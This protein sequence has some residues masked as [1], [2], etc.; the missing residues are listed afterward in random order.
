MPKRTQ[1]VN[2]SLIGIAALPTLAALGICARMLWFIWPDLEM[3][4][5]YGA[6]EGLVLMAA[7]GGMAVIFGLW[8]L[9]KKRALPRLA[10]LFLLAWALL[11]FYGYFHLPDPQ[12]AL[13]S[14]MFDSDT[15]TTVIIA[16]QLPLFYFLLYRLAAAFMIESRRALIWTGLTTVAVPVTLYIGFQ[17]LRFLP[18]GQFFAH[19][20]QVIF[21]TLNAAFS[22]LLLRLFLYLG[23]HHAEKL[24]HLG[25]LLFAQFLFVGALP[26]L[27][28][29]L[30]AHGPLARE[31]QMALGN[32]T[33]FTIWLL[34]LINA[35]LFILPPVQN[36]RVSLVLFAL[37][38][39][40]FIFVLYFCVVFLLFLPLALVLILAFGLGF[41]LLI[42]YLAAA[43]QIVRLRRDLTEL[44]AGYDRKA[45]TAA[46]AAGVL[47]LP[48]LLI[49]HVYR[50]RARLAKT[51]IYVQRPPLN[52]NQQAPVSAGLALTFAKG[53]ERNAR[54]FRHATGHLP[55]YD[56]LYRSIVFDGIEL[57]ENLRRRIG[58]VFSA[59]PA[60]VERAPGRI[61]ATAVL[62]KIETQS[63]RKGILTSSTLRVR[64]SNTGNTASEFSGQITLPDGVFVTGHWLTIGGIEVPAQITTK[65]TA[66]WVYDR[67]TE[68]QR[69]PS[70]IYF[71]GPNTLRWRV[72]PVPAKGF[73]EARLELSH[74]YDAQLQIAGR[75]IALPALTA[76]LPAFSS[77]SGRMQLLAPAKTDAGFTRI[78]YLHFVVDCSAQAPS[79]ALAAAKTAAEKL[80]VPLERARI[81]YVNSSI[82]SENFDGN[83][84]C[85]VRK[86]GFFAE[87]AIRAILHDAYLA[88][89]N[90]FP[91]LV[92]LSPQKL[93]LAWEDLSFARRFYADAD[94]FIQMQ[95]GEM[96][97]HGFSGNLITGGKPRFPLPVRNAGGRLVSA[98]ATLVPGAN[99]GGEKLPALD[100]FEQHLD[101]WSG[102]AAARAHA[103]ITAVESNTL[104]PAAGSIVLETEAQR[105]KLAELHKQMLRAVNEPDAGEPVRMSEPWVYL[106]VI[107]AVAAIARL[108]R[109]K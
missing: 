29:V 7:P 61:A 50:D 76:P 30:N 52:I 56:D 6:I 78:P 27:G 4:R 33:S 66:I 79:D 42:P 25:N 73:R 107:G 54:G 82:R 21:L 103:V 109:R 44:A 43:F 65:N 15:Y 100:G 8:G 5:R 97:V 16:A 3:N 57:S 70:L 108:R 18:Q 63:G 51:I 92:I 35:V 77:S 32:F 89:G 22:F 98:A 68:R 106:L 14:W 58:Q 34:A 20:A 45:I 83:I 71:E 64:F 60:T 36:R 96:L 74:A 104:N 17:A 90:S 88:G 94:G 48:A 86:D 105:R 2:I 85:P 24:Q 1:L 23:R 46:F 80:G 101:F 13:R 69:D 53:A 39:A 62:D 81:S 38:S 41:L 59:G 55:I 75:Q 26:F 28:L 9:C 49:A 47:L 102:D 11:C 31:S 87:L 37:R 99:G 84:N 67:I 91:L 40:G 72:F 95:G 10:K 12:P 19:F 93:A